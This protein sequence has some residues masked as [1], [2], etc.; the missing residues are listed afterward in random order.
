MIYFTHIFELLNKKARDFQTKNSPYCD[1]VCTIRTCVEQDKWVRS[2]RQINTGFLNAFKQSYYLFHDDLVNF[3]PR[4]SS[5]P[6][7]DLG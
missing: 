1:C 6:D 4:L 7:L 3:A 2:C 5:S